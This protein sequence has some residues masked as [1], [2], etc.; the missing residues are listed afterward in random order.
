MSAPHLCQPGK[1][2]KTATILENKPDVLTFYGEPVTVI[3]PSE[4]YVHL[5]V[6]QAP[7]EQSKLAIN[8]RLS[9]GMEMV[10]LHH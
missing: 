2:K 9:K 1:L 3:K 10:Y 5:G 7:T 8:Y 6:V 4:F